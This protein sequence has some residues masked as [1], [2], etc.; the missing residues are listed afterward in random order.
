MKESNN[1]IKSIVQSD[2][3][4]ISI[5]GSGLLKQNIALEKITRFISQ[6]K[7]NVLDMYISEYRITINLKVGIDDDMLES[8][9][10]ELI[11]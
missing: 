8:L 6:N 3:S 10:Q 9:H 11:N 2:V 5:V 1:G 7:L 4:R